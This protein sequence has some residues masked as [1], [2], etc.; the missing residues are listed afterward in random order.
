MSYTD[1]YHGAWHP[2]IKKP[3]L[4]HSNDALNSNS[5]SRVSKQTL[6]VSYETIA[7]RPAISN[8]AYDTLSY[9]S[10]KCVSNDGVAD[11]MDR[12]SPQR[13]ARF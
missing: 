6:T 9:I 11:R 5:S 1:L 7:Q 4:D 8:L 13:A 2:I 12:R 10:P 3:M